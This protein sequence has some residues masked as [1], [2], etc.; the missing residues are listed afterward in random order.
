MEREDLS[1]RISN[2]MPQKNSLIQ[3][4]KKVEIPRFFP[5]AFE[6]WLTNN[7]K[8]MIRREPAAL[9]QPGGLLFIRHVRSACRW[10]T[11]PSQVVLRVLQY[12]FW[13]LSWIVDETVRPLT[14]ACLSGKIRVAATRILPTFMMNERNCPVSM[15]PTR[16]CYLS[17]L[18]VVTNRIFA[19]FVNNVRNCPVSMPPS[20]ACYTQVAVGLG[21]SQIGYL[22]IAWIMY[23]TVQSACRRV[24]PASQV[25]LG[26]PRHGS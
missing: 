21:L 3:P 14:R 10:L 16:A 13:L 5:P 17:R 9:L 4:P 23:E 20:R 22:L 7:Q 1:R 2:D 11:P 19:N 26:L 12:G 24:T 18:R 15:P 6:R 8:L 25:G